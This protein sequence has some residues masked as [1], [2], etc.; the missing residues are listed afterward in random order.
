MIALVSGARGFIGSHLVARLEADGVEVRR[1]QRPLPPPALYAQDP[2]WVGVT[3]VFHL[4]GR[5]RAPRAA[6]LIV[7]NVHGTEQLALA[8]LRYADRTGAPVP[9]FV[10]VSSL[11]ALGPAP[12][13]DAPL[14]GHHVPAPVEAY[15][16]SKRVAEERLQELAALPLTIVRPPAVYGPRD[17]DFLAVF[18][19][20]RHRVQL[21]A[22]PGWHRFTLTHVH[23]VVEALVRVAA[24]PPG[25]SGYL[26]GGDDVTWDAFYD[27]VAG[28]VAELATVSRPSRRPAV[29]LL[30]P[31]PVL[32]T[33]GVLGAAWG[34]LTG[35]TPLATPDKI[36]LGA[37]PYWVCRDDALQN[38]TGWRPSVP[39][40]RGI[41][42][43]AAW[44]LQ[45]GWLRRR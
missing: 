24:A 4:A 15:G 25:G 43:T 3:H 9:R 35:R 18:R 27:Q 39:L 26:I 41:R 34:R 38:D 12:A 31:G 6:D 2:V 36:T 10:F 45:A 30:P 13:A 29:V 19:Q 40:I 21:R 14:T 20:V 1:V 23:D 33:A 28:A 7:A 44:Y 32:R 8:A 11:A 42:D 16:H 22:T 17:R 37:Q 5:T